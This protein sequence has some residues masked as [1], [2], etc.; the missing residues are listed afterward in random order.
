MLYSQKYKA[1]VNIPESFISSANPENE[2]E[3][4]LSDFGFVQR[5]KNETEIKY[6]RGHILGDI[7]IKLAKVNLLI[8]TPVAAVTDISVEAGWVAAFDT[9]DFWKFLAELK[10]KI[11]SQT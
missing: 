3:K 11:E 7:S 2:L 10:E 5:S 6:A 1:Q 8:A 4:Y 9:G